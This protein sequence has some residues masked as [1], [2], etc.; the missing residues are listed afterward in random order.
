MLLRE[1]CV[2]VE[3][4]WEEEIDDWDCA[5]RADTTHFKVDTPRRPK[6]D[7]KNPCEPE[8]QGDL[9]MKLFSVVSDKTSKLLIVGCFNIHFEINPI[10]INEKRGGNFCLVLK[11]CYNITW[12]DDISFSLFKARLSPSSAPL[13]W[14]FYDEEEKE[15]TEKI[16][17]KIKLCMISRA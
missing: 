15:A 14:Y 17:A 13:F 12:C 11:A 10:I 7:G 2:D 1:S 16:G 9:T 3:T 8:T 6:G 5:R 4:A